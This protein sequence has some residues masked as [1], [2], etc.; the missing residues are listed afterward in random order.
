VSA[1]HTA[2]RIVR[3]GLSWEQRGFT[4]IP[5]DWA[6]D[7]RL[8]YR[9]RGILT[10]LM[11]HEVGWSIS[12]VDLA[13]DTREDTESDEE[14]L[15]AVRTAVKQLERRGYIERA[16][17]RDA[18]G[19]VTGTQWSISDPWS[20]PMAL[21]AENPRSKPKCDSPTLDS[22]IVDSPTV[23]EPTVG[24]PTVD[25][26]TTT[27]EHSPEEQDQKTNARTPTGHDQERRTEADHVE[28]CSVNRTTGRHTPDPG[29]GYC[30]A[31]AV[32]IDPVLIGASA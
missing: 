5:N 10:Y 16:R 30:T 19:R 17:T 32:R 13:A 25:S 24:E 7:R 4:R 14:G 15:T 18:K 31:C 12:L 29:S 8:S 26:R 11:S 9:A 22:P 23:G 27:E 3:N 6:R 2:G 28:R 20:V 21:Q 1:P